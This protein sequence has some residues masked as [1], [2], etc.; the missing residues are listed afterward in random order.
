MYL[1]VGHNIGHKHLGLFP[2]E[3]FP[4]LFLLQNYMINQ[5]TGYKGYLGGD[6]LAEFFVSTFHVRSGLGKELQSFKTEI[7]QGI[8]DFTFTVI[9]STKNE[10]STLERDRWNNN[11]LI[12]K[13]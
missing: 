5:G 9:K 6:M 11:I 12:I 4:I 2:L 10:L 13:A 3:S 1:N 8:L 7:P